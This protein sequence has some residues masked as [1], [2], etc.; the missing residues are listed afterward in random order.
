MALTSMKNPKPKKQAKKEM[1][2]CVPS[3]YHE[4]YPYGLEISLHEDSIKK[5]GIILADCQVGD[6]GAVHAQVEIKSIRQS[7]RMNERTG[8]MEMSQNLDLQITDMAFVKGMTKAEH[9]K[10][11]KRAAKGNPHKN[12]Y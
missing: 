2:D 3:P 4:K 8:K 10:L 5:L 1:H 11:T 6:V 12:D 7:D 9:D